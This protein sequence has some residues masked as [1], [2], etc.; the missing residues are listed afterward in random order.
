MSLVHD[1][2]YYQEDAPAGLVTEMIPHHSPTPLQKACADGDI[3]AVIRLVASGALQDESRDMWST[4]V[5]N[6]ACLV[7]DEAIILILLDNGCDVNECHGRALR[8]SIS[9]GDLDIV[10]LLLLHGANPNLVDDPDYGA[11]RCT[12]LPWQGLQDDNEYAA[13]SWSTAVF[14]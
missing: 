11:S 13:G 6:V 7:R 9:R 3:A 8:Q 1:Y 14:Y 4:T 10:E 2:D 12:P 5:L